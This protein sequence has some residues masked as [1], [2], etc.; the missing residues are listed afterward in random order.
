M[1][2]I[3]QEQIKTGKKETITCPNDACRKVFT[4]PLTTL[5]LQKSTKEPY[6]ACPYCLTQITLTENENTDTLSEKALNEPNPISEK[7]IQDQPASCTHY[8][9]Y[10]HEKEHKQQMPEDCLLCSQIMAC[11]AKEKDAS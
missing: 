4:Q 7:P 10:M 8:F 3:V 2:R 1:N 6:N 5:N 11:M 9:G